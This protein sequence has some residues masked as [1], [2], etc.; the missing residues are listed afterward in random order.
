MIDV[1]LPVVT[2]DMDGSPI[3]TLTAT[4]DGSP[5]ITNVTIYHGMSDEHLVDLGKV[6]DAFFATHQHTGLT[7]GQFNAWE[8]K[9]YHAI[10]VFRADRHAKKQSK[11]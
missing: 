2:K 7:D 5:F 10:A 8:D 6:V 4:K 3:V 1:N 11:K 9:A